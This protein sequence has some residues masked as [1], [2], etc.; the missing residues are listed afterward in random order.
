MAVVAYLGLGHG[1]FGVG[2]GGLRGGPADWGREAC[3]LYPKS[4]ARRERA[5]GS[6]VYSAGKFQ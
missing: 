2:A 1:A 3:G 4:R 6:K 5:S